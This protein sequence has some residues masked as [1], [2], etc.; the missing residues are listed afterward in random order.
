MDSVQILPAREIGALGRAYGQ[1]ATCLT[2][3]LLEAKSIP[4]DLR[5]QTPGRRLQEPRATAAQTSLTALSYL[6]HGDM[7]LFFNLGNTCLGQ[8][9]RF[10]KTFHQ[11]VGQVRLPVGKSSCHT[12]ILDPTVK[13]ENQFLKVVSDL[14]ALS[15]TFRHTLYIHHIII[16]IFRAGEMTRWLRA[17]IAPPENLNLIPSIHM[18]AHKGM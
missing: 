18:A 7:G 13:S 12:S 17:L 6:I 16:I 9:W 2:S 4:C 15:C 1:L 5:Q 10:G 14:H 11:R 3:A 8:L